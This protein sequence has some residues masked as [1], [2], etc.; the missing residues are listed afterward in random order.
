MGL[1]YLPIHEWLI[2]M[3]NVSKYTIA[4]VL[5]DKYTPENLRRGHFRRKG[6]SEKA[7]FFNMFVFGG[8]PLVGAC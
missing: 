3:V 1:V 7:P 8:V 4:W 6:S 2:F 5:W